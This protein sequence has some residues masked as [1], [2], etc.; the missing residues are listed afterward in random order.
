M[1]ALVLRVLTTLLQ[2]EYGVAVTFHFEIV[3]SQAC[4]N[5]ARLIVANFD[6]SVHRS[7][8]EPYE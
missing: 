4:L 5:T 6:S 3:L 2:L 1:L 8:A 7:T